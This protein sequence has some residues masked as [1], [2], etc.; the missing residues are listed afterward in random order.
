MQKVNCRQCRHYYITFDASAPYGCRIYG[1]KSK[2]TP[3]LAVFQSSGMACTLFS[4][5]DSG[6]PKDRGPGGGSGGFYA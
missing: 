5:K 4:Q 2:V 6:P 1:F 3:S